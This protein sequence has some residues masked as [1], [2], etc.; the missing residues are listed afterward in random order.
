MPV[1]AR[2]SRD[3]VGNHNVQIKAFQNIDNVTTAI[4]AADQDLEH[5][6]GDIDQSGT[7]AFVTHPISQ[8]GAKDAKSIEPPGIFGSLVARAQEETCVQVGTSIPSTN[9]QVP[10]KMQPQHPL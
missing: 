6:T 10:A 4:T 3:P 8:P 1:A 9:D 7:P 2:T 5:A